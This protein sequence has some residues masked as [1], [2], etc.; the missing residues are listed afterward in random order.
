MV[1]KAH[2]ITTEC[3]KQ[4]V[5][6]GKKGFYETMRKIQVE[7]SLRRRAPI[8]SQRPYPGEGHWCPLG[9]VEL[10]GILIWLISTRV[11]I[12]CKNLMSQNFST[13]YSS[14]HLNI[15]LPIKS[16]SR[17]QN[18]KRND[19]SSLLYWRPSWWGM[20]WTL[21]FYSFSFILVI[22]FL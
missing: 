15:H 22:H 3:M 6:S 4:L 9:Q 13:L 10:T 1:R 12:I 21:L 5:C 18:G 19:N 20:A 17:E 8:W 16:H 11:E 14:L 2:P 7:G